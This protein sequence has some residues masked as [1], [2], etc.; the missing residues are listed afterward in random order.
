MKTTV[1]RGDRNFT[2]FLNVD[3]MIDTWFVYSQ[4]YCQDIK[5]DMDNVKNNW[6]RKQIDDCNGNSG[7]QW[8]II[9]NLTDLSNNTS[10]QEV[11]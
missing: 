5:L 7:Q 11:E 6:F 3:H 1:L 9:N 8:M 2:K 4:R 10:V